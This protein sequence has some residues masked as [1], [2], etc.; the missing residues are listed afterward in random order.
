ML[1][2]FVVGGSFW[3][4]VNLVRD[5]PFELGN[6]TKIAKYRLFGVTHIFHNVPIFQK[7]FIPKSPLYIIFIVVTLNMWLN[8]NVIVVL[9]VL[10]HLAHVSILQGITF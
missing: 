6:V 3:Y 10:F 4:M 5:F 8:K 7:P 1:Y 9:F 2:V